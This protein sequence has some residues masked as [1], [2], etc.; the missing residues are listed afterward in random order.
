MFCLSLHI[1]VSHRIHLFFIQLSSQHVGS[2]PAC[3]ADG[4]PFLSS[5]V[6]LGGFPSSRSV[7][8]PVM[9]PNQPLSSPHY[10]SLLPSIECLWLSQDV[11][12][13]IST[14]CYAF[15]HYSCSHRHLLRAYSLSH[16]GGD[17]EQWQNSFQEPRVLPF[18]WETL[19]SWN[20]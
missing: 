4:L 20:L 14:D 9:S 18:R 7:L 12:L 15:L 10:A 6:V 17:N 19:E 5:T 13:C 3:V 1:P 16:S 8:S 11:L 2:P